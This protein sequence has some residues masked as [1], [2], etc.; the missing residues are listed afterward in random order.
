MLSLL[1]ERRLLT[2]ASRA[3]PGAQGS[4]RGLL[5]GTSSL[6]RWPGRSGGLPSRTHP[7]RHKAPGGRLGPPPEAVGFGSPARH[8]DAQDRKIANLDGRIEAEVEASGST[9][10]EILG[11]GPI[12]AANIIATVGN[13][14]RFPTKADYF[15]SYCGTLEARGRAYYRKK[16]VEGKSSKEALRCLKRRISDAVFRNLMADS[17]APSRSAA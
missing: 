10:T 6:A 7:A 13:A 2:S 3:Y 8:P 11:I 4:L 17:R 9:L 12:L 15:A 5:C 14:A 16:I 1:S